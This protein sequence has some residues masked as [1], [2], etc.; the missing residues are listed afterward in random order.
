MSTLAVMGIVDAIVAA[1]WDGTE[2]VYTLNSN[3]PPPEAGTGF[4][5]ITYPMAKEDQIGIADDG[6]HLYRVDGGFVITLH[7]PRTT[8]LTTPLTN[9]DTLRAAFR[10]YVDPTGHFRIF[11]V[12]PVLIPDKADRGAYFELQFGVTYEFDLFG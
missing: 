8:S 11:G 10:G 6:S 9:L 7:L 2:P 5:T 3:G 1:E 12:N 4:L